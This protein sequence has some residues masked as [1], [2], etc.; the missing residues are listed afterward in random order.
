MGSLLWEPLN[1]EPLNENKWMLI[2]CWLCPWWH[3]RFNFCNCVKG[4]ASCSSSRQS[5]HPYLWFFKEQ[6]LILLVSAEMFK[7]IELYKFV[8]LKKQFSIRILHNSLL[9]PICYSLY[10]L[11]NIRLISAC[12]LVLEKEMTTPPVFLPG[13]SHGQRSMVG[14]RP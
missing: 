3:L 6:V 12:G 1:V 4:F 8:C 13:D 5:I 2:P 7:F 10:V 14:C 9:I 11:K